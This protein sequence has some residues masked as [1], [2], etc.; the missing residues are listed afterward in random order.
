MLDEIRS[1]GFSSVELSHGIRVSLI[2]GIQRA[3]KSNPQ[4]R[5]VS[6][7]NFCPLPVGHLCAAPN[8]YL[9]SSANEIERQKAIRHTL[10]TMDFAVKLGAGV[11]VLHLGSVPMKSFTHQLLSLIH[12]GQRDTPAYQKTLEKAL[13]KRADGG[14]KPF[15]QTMKSMEILAAAAKERRLLLGVESRFLLEEIPSEKEFEELFKFF[16]RETVGYWHDSGHTQTWQNLGLTDHVKW[17]QKFQGRLIG[18]HLHDTAYPNIDHQLPGDGAVPFE[19]LTAF[20]RSDVLKVFEFEDG[21]PVE[22]LKERLSDFMT[23]FEG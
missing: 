15:L 17:L 19:Q 16:D 3:L 10:Q 13:K 11:V 12:K 6:L 5:V 9:L 4:L 20:R 21:M 2:E 23:R 22:N 1:L 7:H 14:R 8:I 18:G